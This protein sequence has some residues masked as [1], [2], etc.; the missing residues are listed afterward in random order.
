M[1]INVGPVPGQVHDTS[2]ACKRWLRSALDRQH[3]LPK[4]VYLHLGVDAG[5]FSRWCS[6][7]HHQTLPMG[8]LLRVLEL[9]DA[10]ALE[11]LILIL[12]G[13]Q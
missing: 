6:Y 11:D 2:V 9:M 12:R 8:A 1:N 13:A 7:E 4:Q 10:Q 5:T 3:I